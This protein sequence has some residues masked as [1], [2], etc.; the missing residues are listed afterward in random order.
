VQGA[1]LALADMDKA[2]V[3]GAGF[4]EV[5]GREAEQARVVA[6]EARAQFELFV[7]PPAG[8][9]FGHGGMTGVGGHGTHPADLLLLALRGGDIVGQKVEHNHLGRIALEHELFQSVG[10]IEILAVR[11]GVKNRKVKAV[12]HDRGDIVAEGARRAEADHIVGLAEQ[13]VFL[14]P[15]FPVEGFPEKVVDHPAQAV[16]DRGQQKQEKEQPGE[17]AA[18]P[19]TGRR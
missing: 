17:E 14:G 12:L 11:P 10:V 6:V 4:V 2:V 1:E 8:E 16:I 7:E 13:P 9:Q 18:D 3:H 19:R 5:I 15:V